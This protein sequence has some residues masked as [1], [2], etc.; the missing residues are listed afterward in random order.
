MQFTVNQCS[1][2]ISDEWIRTADLWCQ[3]QPLCQLSH[4]HCRKEEYCSCKWWY[5]KKFWKI[6][7]G[8]MLSLTKADLLQRLDH[9]YLFLNENIFLIIRINRLKHDR[10]L[11]KA[12]LQFSRLLT[13][14]FY[15]QFSQLVWMRNTDWGY[16]K[17]GGNKYYFWECWRMAMHRFK[18]VWCVC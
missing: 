13:R 11:L 16:R 2:T 12:R 15:V 6:V 10:S 14:V 4:N 8:N 18:F 17:R 9:F 1:L 7:F 3:K 5:L